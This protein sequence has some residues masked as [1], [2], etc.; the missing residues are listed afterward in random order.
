MSESRLDRAGAAIATMC[1]VSSVPFSNF[2]TKSRRSW[3]CLTLSAFCNYVNRR[4]PH[5]SANRHTWYRT[6]RP[7]VLDTAKNN[8]SW[9]PTS[10]IESECTI[11]YVCRPTAALSV[12]VRFDFDFAPWFGSTTAREILDL[13]TSAIPRPTKHRTRGLQRATFSRSFDT[14]ATCSVFESSFCC[15]KRDS[16]LN[17]DHLDKFGDGHSPCFESHCINEKCVCS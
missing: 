16:V 12:V 15:R 13:T 10:P 17:G 6:T 3:N 4:L 14:P 2:V 11:L 9:K 5:I 1:V 8:V 7:D